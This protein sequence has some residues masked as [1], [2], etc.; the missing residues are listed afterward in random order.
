MKKIRLSDRI[1]YAFDNLMAKGA[2]AQ[3]I[4]LAI[5]T[6]ITVGLFAIVVWV[7]NLSPEE[8]YFE[9]FWAYLALT[10]EAE[11][12]TG[13]HWLLRISTFIVT[14]V[15]IFITS[16]LIGLL[17]TSIE[18]KIEDLRKGRSHVIEN[19]HTVILGWTPAIFPIISELVIANEN[20]KKAAIVILGE[21]DKV[22]ME[23]EIHD[24]VGNTGKTR[25]VCRTGNPMN[26]TDLDITSL[27]TSRSIMVLGTDEEDPDLGVIKTL[28]A[29]TN[30]PNRRS[31]LYHIV[32]EINNRK[33]LQVAKIAGHDEVEFV[34]LNEI[35]SRI[36]A[37]TSRQS[38]LSIAYVE[39]LDFGG[40][41]IY[42]KNEPSLAGLSFSEALMAYEDS[43]LIGLMS[44]DGQPKLNPP[45]DTIIGAEDKV[46]AISEDD[47]TI[48]V[49][50]KTSF[51]IQENQIV[52]Y[53][54][55]LAKS[56]NIIIL[57]F[58]WRAPMI[59]NELDAYV[60]PQSKLTIVTNFPDAEELI[61]WHCRNTK[62][63]KIKFIKADSTDRET[64]DELPFK[65]H[66]NVILLSSTGLMTAERADART[67]ISLLHLR[68]IKEKMGYP[69]T[70]VSEILDV[71]NQT[72]A[73]VAQADDFVVS[74]RLI[75][76]ML[77]QISENKDLAAIFED[78]L[79]LDG[80]EIYI[81]PI[82]KYLKTGTPVNFYTAVESA[83][84]CNQVAIGYRIASLAKD[85]EQSFGVFLN[86][87]KSEQIIFSEDDQLI[88]LAEE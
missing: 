9:Q 61:K 83:K 58:N 26:M 81:K 40:D 6:L 36:T 75:S 82:T 79:D 53:K 68:D 37:Q 12:L 14:M 30:N 42:Y 13:S 66:H 28:L 33:N 63:L 31:N 32:A 59:I 17:S 70:I 39:L 4:T 1:R 50:G 3:I 80:S 60:A 54:Q 44:A 77:T 18:G 23:E 76:L 85:S 48:H 19:G 34:L 35:L 16:I 27:N 38:G 86:P 57:G 15:A 2:I 87:K 62:N 69:I 51:S 24:K 7:T 43:T 73:E 65:D 21:K 64:L 55:S 5:F 72:L 56:E 8:N 71:R 45:M 29:I 74:D 67:L 41:E 22:E 25:V 46:I 84:R 10:L 11:T 47:D 52:P 49:S 88:V 78:I 20:R